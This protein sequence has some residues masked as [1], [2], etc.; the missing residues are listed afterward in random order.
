M[1][2]HT[3]GALQ[4]QVGDGEGVGVSGPEGEVMRRPGT[5]PP[6]GD[7]GFNEL[8]ERDRPVGDDR[9]LGDRCGEATDGGKP[10]VARSDLA[11][12][13]GLEVGEKSADEI[14][15]ERSTTARRSTD[16]LASLQR[17]G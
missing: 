15:T 6:Q 1:T 10:L 2:V 5:Q 14:R 8:V 12:P 9:A 17:T 3:G 16:F 7:D 11:T 4:A 13:R